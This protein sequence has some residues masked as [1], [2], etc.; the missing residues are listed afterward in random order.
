MSANDVPIQ[1]RDR[2]YRPWWRSG[3]ASLATQQKEGVIPCSPKP[4]ASI[5]SV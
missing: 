1:E 5:T 3:R 4:E 2:R